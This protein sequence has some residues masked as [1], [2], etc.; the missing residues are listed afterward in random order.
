MKRISIFAVLLISA[1]GSDQTNVSTPSAPPL[2]VSTPAAPPVADHAHPIVFIGD[3][4]MARWSDLTTLVPNSVN[5]GVGGETTAQMLAR[6]QTDVLDLHPRLIVLEGGVNDIVSMVD[7]APDSTAA[8]VQMAQAAGIRV[9]VLAVMP[10]VIPYAVWEYN[11]KLKAMTQAYGVTYVDTFY[12]FCDA[13]Y[14]MRP[15]LFL[16]D[17]VHLSDAGYTVLWNVLKPVIVTIE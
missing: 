13:A 15:E 6:F 5:K 11:V 3:S 2:S 17:G 9:I 14:L 7:P 4:I 8:M 10:A 1:C 12:P 16:S